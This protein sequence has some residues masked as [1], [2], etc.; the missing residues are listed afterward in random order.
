M[1]T[2]CRLNWDF[3]AAASCKKILYKEERV[4]NSLYRS[5]CVC[6]VYSYCTSHCFAPEKKMSASESAIH[7]PHLSVNRGNLG[8]EE[9]L[10]K[11]G[12]LPN[13]SLPCFSFCIGDLDETVPSRPQPALTIHTGM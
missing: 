6:T 3:A 1:Q 12:T 9:S 8:L 2:L 13:G 11:E 4:K 10:K 5:V 7:C